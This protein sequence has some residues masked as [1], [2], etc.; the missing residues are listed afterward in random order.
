MSSREQ[1]CHGQNLRG[2]V[3]VDCWDV[4]GA[5]VTEETRAHCSC[6][7]CC[8]ARKDGFWSGAIFVPREATEMLLCPDCGYKRCPHATS[9]KLACTGSNEPGQHG[10]AY[11]PSVNEEN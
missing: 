10:S 4:R 3:V 8:R 2:R 5:A 11:G 7:A 1:V 6:R 9:H